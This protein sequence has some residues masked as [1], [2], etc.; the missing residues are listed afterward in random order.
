MR[1]SGAIGFVTTTKKNG[2]VKESTFERKYKGDILRAN[3]GTNSATDQVNDDVTISNQLSILCDPFIRENLYAIK[4]ATW[5]GNK[6]KISSVD[7]Q[8]PRLILT[9]GGLYNGK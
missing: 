1:Y 3:R 2:I 4:Y 8:Y 6:W 9:L 5:Y 7:I